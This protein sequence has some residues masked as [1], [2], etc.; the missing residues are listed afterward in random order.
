MLCTWGETMVELEIISEKENPFLERKEV[1]AK[2][3]HPGE[4]T[5]SKAKV[6]ELLAKKYGVEVTHIKIDY[7]FSAFGKPES[8]VKAKVYKKPIK[9]VKK[10]EKEG[11][12]QSQASQGGGGSEASA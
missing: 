8:K 10:E 3:S 6:E 7:I 9:E 11:E 4:A 2:L 1:I 5:P 12:A